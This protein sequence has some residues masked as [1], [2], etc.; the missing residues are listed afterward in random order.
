MCTQDTGS[1]GTGVRDSCELPCGWWE[2]NLDPL[3]E[4]QVLLTDYPFLQPL[5]TGFMFAD[6]TKPKVGIFG[7]NKTPQN[8]L[9]QC[10]PAIPE[11]VE[12]S[13]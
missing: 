8:Q 12:R 11:L 3:E 6:A 13:P 7:G 10:M 5:A 1:P 4:Q 9:C 2:L